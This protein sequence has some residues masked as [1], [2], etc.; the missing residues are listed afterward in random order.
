MVEEKGVKLLKDNLLIL[1]EQVLRN[2]LINQADNYPQ[3]PVSGGTPRMRDAINDIDRTDDEEND[4][5][6][7]S[8]IK[9]SD[10]L[11]IKNR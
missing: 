8:Q 3:A 10:F 11:N 6:W 9:I 2:I 1:S 4:L 7:T 5:I